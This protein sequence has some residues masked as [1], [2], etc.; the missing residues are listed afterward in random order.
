[1]QSVAP[2]WRNDCVIAAL[3]AKF[4]QGKFWKNFLRY[5]PIGWPISAVKGLS[6]AIQSDPVQNWLRGTTGSG[7]TSA[8]VQQNAWNSQEAAI[9][10]DWQEQM[11]ATKYQRQTQDMVAA[12]LNPAMLY[13]GTSSPSA[14]SGSAASGGDAGSPSAGMMDSILNVIFAS[15]RLKNL[16]AEERN[17]ESQSNKNDA[18]AELARSNR[19]KSI[20]DTRLTNLI[21]DWYPNLTASTVTKLDRESEKLGSEL[22]V[23]EHQVKDIDASV[24]LKQAQTSVENVK[25]TWLPKLYAAQ[26]QS[27]RAKALS[28]FAKAAYD[29]YVAE[30]LHGTGMIP[31]ANT[32]TSIAAAIISGSG[33]DERISSDEFDAIMNELR[34]CLH[35]EN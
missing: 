19:E 8:E 33:L 27:E 32:V 14:L 17:I 31:G 7:L 11:D 16:K 5:T 4:F 34:N 28:D 13:G 10:R 22:V 18:D 12:G 24:A 6:S 20:A 15:Q 2:L 35:L 3:M 9:N 1:M 25:N 23:L 26:S 21:A 30:Y 29:A